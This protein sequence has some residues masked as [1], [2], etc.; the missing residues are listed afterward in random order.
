[1][2]A[3]GFKNS[4]IAHA[5]GWKGDAMPARYTAHLDAQDSAAVMLAVMQGRC[6]PYLQGR[7]IRMGQYPTLEISKGCKK[8]VASRFYILHRFRSCLSSPIGR[9]PVVQSVYLAAIF[10]DLPFLQSCLGFRC[11]G[12]LDTCHSEGHCLVSALARPSDQTGQ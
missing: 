5:F 10:R 2:R 11:R 12:M 4:D 7:F 9:R 8:H 6:N 1:M 3:A